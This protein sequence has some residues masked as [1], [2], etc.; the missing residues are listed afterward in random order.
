MLKTSLTELDLYK[1]RSMN[2]FARAKLVVQILFQHNYITNPVEQMESTRDINGLRHDAEPMNCRFLG[3][4]VC[5]DRTFYLVEL[6]APERC[7]V[8]L[9]ICEAMEGSGYDRFAVIQSIGIEFDGTCVIDG[10][11]DHFVRTV[12]AH[13]GEL[14]E[15]L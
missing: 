6:D 11:Y 15:V 10:A 14:M 12:K 5:K 8:M 9:R 13:R 2:Q 7:L 4:G 1:M 3:K